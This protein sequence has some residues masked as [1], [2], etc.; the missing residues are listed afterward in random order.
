MVSSESYNTS[1]TFLK[2]NFLNA[3]LQ[4]IV[5]SQNALQYQELA[6]ANATILNSEIENAIYTDWNET[7][8]SIA[9]QISNLS[10]SDSNSTQLQQ[11]ETQYQT[12]SA[13]AQADENS[14][15]AMTQASQQAVTQ[16]GTNIQN[17]T[18]LGSVLFSVSSNM[19]SILSRPL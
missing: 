10:T 8:S 6:D 5:Q 13:K 14:A 4:A 15:D 11:L 17:Q 2:T 12:A 16:D 7:L 18:S 9:D 3:G 19:A 1:P